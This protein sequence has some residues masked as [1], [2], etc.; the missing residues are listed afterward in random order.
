MNGKTE[1]QKL[2][3]DDLSALRE[4]LIRSDSLPPSHVR[5]VASPIIRRWLIDDNLN[6]LA[7][8]LKVEF[9]LRYY[10]RYQILIST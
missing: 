10:S 1:L 2:L 7:K 5:I 8:D 6:K 3:E 9:E 4:L